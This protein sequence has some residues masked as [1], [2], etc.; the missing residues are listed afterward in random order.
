MNNNAFLDLSDYRRSIAE[1]YAYIRNSEDPPEERWNLYRRVRDELFR[2]HPQSA[3]SQS[4]QSVFP[5]LRYYPYDPAYRFILPVDTGVEPEMIE[6][7]LEEDGLTRLKRFGKVHFDVQ[8]QR[9]FLSLFWI[10]GYGGG[11]FLPFR[12]LTNQNGTYGGGRYLLD[13]IKGADLGQEGGRLVFDFNFAYN[14]S[15]AYNP[16]WVCPL[17]PPENALPVPIY[18]GELDFLDGG[19]E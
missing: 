1:L 14:P 5:G 17:A 10:V 18:A 7:A 6:V 4:Q 3:L 13:T 15:C 16:R 19:A 12:D 9:V 11:I 2:S 8:G